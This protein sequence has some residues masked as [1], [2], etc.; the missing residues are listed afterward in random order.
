MEAWRAASSPS[1]F[2]QQATDDGLTP[3]YYYVNT[4]KPET[5]TLYDGESVVFH[6]SVPGHHLQ[7]S[8]AQSLPGLPAFRREGGST[9]YI[10]GWALYCE[11]LADELGLYSSPL[12][13]YGMLGGQALRAVRLV[14]DTGMHA[15]HWTR[16][17]ALDF[18]LAHTSD[19]PHAAANEIDRY[20]A[21]PGQALGYMVGEQEILKLRAEAKAK[22]GE[23]FDIRGFHDAVL[24]HGALPLPVLQ[25]EI[26]HCRAARPGCTAA[27]RAPGLA[28]SPAGRPR[29][30]TPARRDSRRCGGRRK[31]SP[32]RKRWPRKLRCSRNRCPSGR[33]IPS[34]SNQARG[35][36]RRQERRQ[37][38]RWAK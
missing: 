30:R 28:R 12:A 38:P 10:E 34:P 3:A 37:A 19:D 8:I 29:R 14:V 17:Q 31:T 5:R 2:Y 24:L 18:F 23:R 1:A 36:K 32:S 20:I 35:Q 15:K 25:D 22:L 6:E 11:R 4:D 7:V 16:Q 33:P 26:H 9:A 27:A 21:W 13:R